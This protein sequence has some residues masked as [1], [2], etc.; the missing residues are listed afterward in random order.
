MSG[1]MTPHSEKLGAF[2]NGRT[3]NQMKRLDG[4]DSIKESNTLLRRVDR[5]GEEPEESGK[6]G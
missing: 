3:G 6:E 2:R 1:V 4:R 5:A